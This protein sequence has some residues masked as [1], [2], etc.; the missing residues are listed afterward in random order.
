MTKLVITYS[1]CTI[2]HDVHGAIFEWST[3]LVSFS[4]SPKRTNW[5]IQHLNIYVRILK[6]FCWI[7]RMYAHYLQL[8]VSVKTMKVWS[9][10]SCTP[11]GNARPSNTTWVVLVG[12]S[13]LRSLPV[14][15]PSNNMKKWSL[16]NKFLST[17]PKLYR[18]SQIL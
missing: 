9:L 12:G 3:N 5:I 14:D 17:A 15:S 6:F 16:Q 18:N 4:H 13:Y 1:S 2:V 11:F 10:D 8:V 7:T